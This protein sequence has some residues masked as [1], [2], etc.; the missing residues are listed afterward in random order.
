ME[1]LS[2]LGVSKYS[3]MSEQ[4]CNRQ[5]ANSSAANDFPNNLKVL[6]IVLIYCYCRNSLLIIARFL[7]NTLQN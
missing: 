6:I 2:Q 1:P 3:L 7:I 4:D 5:D